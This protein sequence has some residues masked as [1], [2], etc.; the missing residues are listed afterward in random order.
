MVRWNSDGVLYLLFV[1]SEGLEGLRGISFV[2]S[3]LWDN[4]IVIFSPVYY[5]FDLFSF[6]FVYF[7]VC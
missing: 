1:L 5:C 4:E 3:F 6:A 2:E 7:Y